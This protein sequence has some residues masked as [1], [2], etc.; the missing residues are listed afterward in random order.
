MGTQPRQRRGSCSRTQCSHP[1]PGGQRG[2]PRVAAGQSK[3]LMHLGGGCLTFTAPPPVSSLQRP[4]G[5]ARCW[6]AAARTH[7]GGV[8]SLHGGQRRWEVPAPALCH[9]LPF[10]WGC[11][12]PQGWG[13]GAG[14]GAPPGRGLWGPPGLG[15][16]PV[17]P[18]SEGEE[19]AEE[20]GGGGSQGGTV[21]LS[22]PLSPGRCRADGR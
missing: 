8:R 12:E 16:F 11:P 10:Q 3:G 1:G 5:R 7:F 13:G 9:D 21:G 14:A 22:P 15:H 6:G 2:L 19:G 18:L 4:Q 20:G 17:L